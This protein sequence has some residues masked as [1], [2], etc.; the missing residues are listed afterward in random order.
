[1]SKK[2]TTKAFPKTRTVE[3]INAE[4]QPLAAYYGDLVSKSEFYFH[5]S[6]AVK[7]KIQK[8]HKEHAAVTR[9]VTQ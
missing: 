8:L 4:Y 6:L 2:T 5:E 7:D 1:M 9:M 3:Q